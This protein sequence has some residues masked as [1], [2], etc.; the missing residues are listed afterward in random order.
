[1][2]KFLLFDRNQYEENDKTVAGQILDKMLAAFDFN[3]GWV[4]PPKLQLVCFE[5]KTFACTFTSRHE[6]KKCLDVETLSLE[7]KKVFQC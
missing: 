4:K 7:K 5:R 3:N 1:M 6:V 2:I